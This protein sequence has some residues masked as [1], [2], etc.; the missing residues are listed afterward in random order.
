MATTALLPS[1]QRQALALAA[2]GYTNKEIAREMA[3]TRYTA[4]FY[5][6]QAR[7]QLGATNTTHAVVVAIAVGL[8]DFDT[9]KEKVSGTFK[10]PLT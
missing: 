5:L 10:V 2:C 7:E 8:I 4:S 1:R 9:L 3:I 6:Q